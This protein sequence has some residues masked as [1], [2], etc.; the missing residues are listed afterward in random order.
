MAA[1]RLTGG[2][3]LLMRKLVKVF[4]K[5]QSYFG[6]GGACRRPARDQHN[7]K[8]P[9]PTVPIMSEVFAAQAFNSV[10]LN[11]GADFFGHDKPQARTNLLFFHIEKNE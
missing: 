11:G 9:G 10:P 2:Q 7:I 1:S 3:G 4:F 8:G 5:A 6:V